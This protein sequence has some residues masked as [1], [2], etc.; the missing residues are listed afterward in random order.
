MLLVHQVGIVLLKFAAQRGVLGGNVVG[1]GGYQK[2]QH[3]IPLDVPKE[4]QTQAF[5]LRRPFNDSGNVGHHK[6]LL[7][8][9][10]HHAEVGSQ[11]GEGIVCDFRF[12]G[13]H[14]AQKGGFSGVGKAHESDVREQF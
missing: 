10:G 5:S 12:G 11:G 7:V 4:P 14:H 2:E 1:I 8:A 3:G 9:V 13:A 6:A